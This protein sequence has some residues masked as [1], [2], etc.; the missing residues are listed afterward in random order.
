M[1]SII[2]L[3]SDGGV[4]TT[5]ANVWTP[6]PIPELL[7]NPKPANSPAMFALLIL[8]VPNP[9]ASGNNFPGGTFGISVDGNPQL[10]IGCF[11][12]DTVATS[13]GPRISVTVVSQLP[14][15]KDDHRVRAIWKGV[16]GCTVHIDT[17]ATLSA[18]IAP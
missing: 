15:D 2:H 14:L 11:T 10:E 12:Y 13:G 9:Y 4:Y 16:R 1:A 6:M 18:I 7:L 3:K 17:P 8:A 5:D